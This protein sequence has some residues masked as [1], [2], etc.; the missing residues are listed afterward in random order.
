ALQTTRDS[1]NCARSCRRRRI[2]PAHT[3]SPSRILFQSDTT[4]PFL[5]A[6]TISTFLA[7]PLTYFM[8]DAA[9]G[10]SP[11][12][13][14][15]LDETPEPNHRQPRHC[16]DFSCSCESIRSCL[17]HDRPIPG[18]D[19][20]PSDLDCVSS[21]GHDNCDVALDWMGRIHSTTGV[22]PIQRL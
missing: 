17:P 7:S 10:S 2:L 13:K 3:L 4:S 12:N 6:A 18:M 11:I 19:G 9:V 16:Q 8:M 22:D 15:Y 20:A 1:A 21:L 14:H 5:T